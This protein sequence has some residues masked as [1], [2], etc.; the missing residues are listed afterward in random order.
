MVRMLVHVFSFVH[1]R[2][3]HERRYCNL[4]AASKPEQ[5]T[6]QSVLLRWESTHGFLFRYLTHSPHAVCP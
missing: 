6:V 4:T 5:M 3:P 2:T 1:V